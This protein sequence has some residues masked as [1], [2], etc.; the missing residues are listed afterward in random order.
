MERSKP[1]S[2]PAPGISLVI[3]I[4]IM[5]SCSHKFEGDTLDLGMYQWNL[6]ADPEASFT[7]PADPIQPGPIPMDPGHE[8]SCGWE[9]FHRG[10]GKLVRIPA[11]MNDHLESALNE[12]NGADSFRGTA[13]YHSRFTLPEQWEGRKITLEFEE[14]GP[15][16]EVYLNETF[17]GGYQGKNS[18]FSLDVTGTIY[19]TRDNHL[20]IRIT[21]SNGEGGGITG[22]LQV[23]PGN[24]AHPE[25]EN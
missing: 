22:S 15:Y 24:P 20:S 3:L 21:D 1:L 5:G 6:W 17:V 2:F 10:K 7:F 25:V 14:A 18:T 16:V 19:Y 11:R 23:R 4:L 12:G 8:P 13:W 9:E